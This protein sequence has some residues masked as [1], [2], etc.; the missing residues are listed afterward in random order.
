MKKHYFQE[1]EIWHFFFVWN[2]VSIFVIPCIDFK[3]CPKN[4][5]IFGCVGCISTGKFHSNN[6]SSVVPNDLSVSFVVTNLLF[7]FEEQ[8]W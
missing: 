5:W 4:N 2:N 8:L 6:N 7:S 1:W 3:S